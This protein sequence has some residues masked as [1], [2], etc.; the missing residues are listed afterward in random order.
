MRR[1]MTGLVAAAALHAVALVLAHE[2]VY[3]SRYGSRFGEA[4]VHSGHGSG[5]SAAVT[6]S[7][8][9][10][11]ALLLVSILRLAW[12]G[13]LVR[14]HEAGVTPA[15]LDLRPL[16]L[17]WLRLAPRLAM[18][19]VVILTV[20][21]NFE[22]AAIGQSMPEPSILL[23]A[24]YAGGIWIA[25]AVGALV[26]LVAALFDWR[27]RTLLA[28]LR[29]AHAALPRPSAGQ[30]PRPALIETPAISIIG[31]RSALRAPPLQGVI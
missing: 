3:L 13:A 17:T 30:P 25:L 26:A 5:W 1:R 20:Q 11:T 27:R 6:T 7:L 31:R 9:L 21:E 23:T 2:L 16:A 12:L 29:A 28:R 18:L 19:T 4:L 15:P 24:E 10:A 14:R 22:R 8:A